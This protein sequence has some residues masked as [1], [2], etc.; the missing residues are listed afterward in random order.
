MK[1]LKFAFEI[2]SPLVCNEKNNIYEVCTCI[3]L[4]DRRIHY[5]NQGNELK[6]M[7]IDYKVAQ[8][9]SITGTPLLRQFLLG[10]ISN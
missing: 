1:T 5:H 8:Y 2:N 4:D 7:K 10:R 6:Q 3:G 9:F